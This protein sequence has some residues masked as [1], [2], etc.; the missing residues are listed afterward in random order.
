MYI[1]MPARAKSP[2]KRTTKKSPTKRTTKRNTKKSPTKRTIKKSPTKRTTKK[3]PTKRTTKRTTK[4]SPTKRTTKSKRRTKRGRDN[5]TIRE[6]EDYL[7]NTTDSAVRNKL[8]R[9]MDMLEDG[10]PKS[11]MR[12]YEMF[13]EI[14]EEN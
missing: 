8:R 11:R 9:V 13:E 5:E 12:A 4:K 14:K 7:D 3:S 1:K 10:D 6:V 2:T